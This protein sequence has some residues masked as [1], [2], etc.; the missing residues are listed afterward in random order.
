MKKI[1]LFLFISSAIFAQNSGD[2]PDFEINHQPFLVI[3]ASPIEI[4]NIHN[5]FM[6]GAELAPPFG[7][8]S[9]QAD[10]GVGS[11]GFNI[12][13]GIRNNFSSLQTN[14]WRGE[15]RTYQSDWFYFSDLDR[16]PLGRYFALEYAN[17]DISATRESFIQQPSTKFIT[18][19]SYKLDNA[20]YTQ[21]ETLVNL[22][23][24]KHFLFKRFLVFDVYGGFG[25]RKY[26][27]IGV[28][29][30]T[31]FG[32]YSG[33]WGIGDWLPNSKGF[34]PNATFGFRVCVPL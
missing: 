1:G 8:F 9:L 12:H 18:Q 24:G 34:L 32:A 23:Y 6:I 14:I 7:K 29:S 3:T 5:T 10:Y 27:V 20:K 21:N 2:K 33:Y 11:R 15:L 13:P 30:K 25:I 17:K 26:K 28:D 4:F 16:K 19:G 22:K 31:V